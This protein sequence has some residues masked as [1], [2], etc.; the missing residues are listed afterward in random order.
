MPAQV[1]LRRDAGKVGPAGGPWIRARQVAR[2]T[3]VPDPGDL[4]QLLDRRGEPLGWGL[5]SESSAIAVRMLTWGADPPAAD[6]LVER[7]DRAFAAR[8]TLGFAE[9]PTTGI[10]MIN[11]EGDG[12]PG[13]VVDRYDD[14]LVMQQGTA[15]MV[16]RHEAILAALRRRHAGPIHTV[17]PAA[18]AKAEGFA[19]GVERE[20][21]DPWLRF[22]EHGL[23]M[24]VPAPPSQKTGAYLDQRANRRWVAALARHGEGPL[25][26]LGCHVGGFGLHAAAAGVEAVGVDGS[27]AMLERAAEHARLNGLEGLRFVEADMFGALDDPRLAG[28]FGTIVVDPPK[29]AARRRDVERAATAMQR[30]VARVAARLR[31]GGHLVLCSCSHHL[32]V[33]ALDRSILAAAGSWV[34]IA[35]RGADVDHPIAPGHVEGEYLR[36][37]TYQR[38]A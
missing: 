29:L 24:V 12:L 20:G 36:V 4:V 14:A 28:P 11:S 23:R 3:G 18:A 35:V 37:A 15:P 10:R 17:R 26:D 1:Q 2:W 22:T 8:A 31:V 30:L 6:W 34:R 9:Q 21:D 27:A 38:R 7:I 19:G 33:D 5:P 13:L 25:L 32:G 16:A